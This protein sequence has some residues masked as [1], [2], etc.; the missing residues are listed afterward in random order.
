VTGVAGFPAG[1]LLT[2]MN[3]RYGCTD[4][5][6][7]VNDLYQ[8]WD[9]VRKNG[10]GQS[11]INYG[12]VSTAFGHLSTSMGSIKTSFN[13]VFNTLNSTLSAVI[14][15]TYGLLSGLNCLVIG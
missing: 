5:N 12:S 9:I 10:I 3:S 4:V 8:N 6:N 7:Y 11:K 2:D 13:N 1:D 14:D 15:P